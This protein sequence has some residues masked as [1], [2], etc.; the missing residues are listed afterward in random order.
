MSERTVSLRVL[1][2]RI[3]ISHQSWCR[4][5]CYADELV[6]RMLI[7]SWRL[8]FKQ[9]GLSFFVEGKLF[10]S[11]LKTQGCCFNF[12]RIYGT[13][14]IVTKVRFQW[15]FAGWGTRVERDRLWLFCLLLGGEEEWAG[16]LLVENARDQSR[17]LVFWLPSSPMLART[18]RI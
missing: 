6:D 16:K 8:L 9:R 2:W 18:I 15:S 12:S 10:P 1:V 7:V 11:K 13:I 14:I 3:I 5:S 4:L 17:I